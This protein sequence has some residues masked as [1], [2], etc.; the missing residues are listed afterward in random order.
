MFK[1]DV[2]DMVRVD[3]LRESGTLRQF[4]ETL[5]RWTLVDLLEE[6]IINNVFD[7][8]TDQDVREWYDMNANMS[9]INLADCL[10]ISQD[11]LSEKAVSK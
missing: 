2:I 5:D 11:Q 10:G 4:L 3:D 7:L 8:G 9:L 1:K 6:Q